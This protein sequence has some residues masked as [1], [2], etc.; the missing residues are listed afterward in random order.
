MFVGQFCIKPSIL[1][2][3]VYTL[4]GYSKNDLSLKL[5]VILFY[6]ASQGFLLRHLRV[7]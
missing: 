3:V 5:L 7:R 2:P 6:I 1:F 4:L